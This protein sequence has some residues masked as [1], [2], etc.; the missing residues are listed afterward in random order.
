ME[1]DCPLCKIVAN[2]KRKLYYQ[3]KLVIVTNCPTCKTP[4]VVLKRHTM[5]PNNFEL[6]H[7]EMVA[8]ELFGKN[9]KFRKKP[10][11][12]LGHIHWHILG[13]KT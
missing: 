12:I 8:K 9:I 13:G 5:K 6:G 1:K 11:Q 7:M 3:D 4:I 2:K 10:R